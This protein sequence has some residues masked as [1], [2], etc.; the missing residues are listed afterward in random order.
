MWDT[1]VYLSA[2]IGSY[3][4]KEMAP[5]LLL[6]HIQSIVDVASRKEYGTLLG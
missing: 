6:N 5:K 4:M 2:M 3:I 1:V